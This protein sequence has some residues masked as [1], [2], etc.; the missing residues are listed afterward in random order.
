ME[1]VV[2]GTAPL[3]LLRYVQGGGGLRPE[4]LGRGRSLLLLC[5]LYFE[6]FGGGV[7]RR[8]FTSSIVVYRPIARLCI[9]LCN[10]SDA[11]FRFWPKSLA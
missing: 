9:S 3:L 6:F 4:A 7:A 8:A 2:V 10:C 11:D 5:A 1:G